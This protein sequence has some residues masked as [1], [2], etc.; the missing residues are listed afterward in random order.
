LRA[1]NCRAEAL[2][3]LEQTILRDRNHASVL[4]WSVSHETLRGSGPELN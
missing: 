2:A 4:A 1:Y 3:A